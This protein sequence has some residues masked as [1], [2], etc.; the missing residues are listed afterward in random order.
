MGR[1]FNVNIAGSA[2]Q[3]MLA[4][5]SSFLYEM[6]IYQIHQDK[7]QISTIRVQAMEGRAGIIAL[8]S[9]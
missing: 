7:R 4:L 9:D 3:T 1:I 5:C 6:Q 8:I 2:L